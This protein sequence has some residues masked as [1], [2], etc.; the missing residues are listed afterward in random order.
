MLI[1]RFAKEIIIVQIVQKDRW[2]EEVEE[3]V[4]KEFLEYTFKINCSYY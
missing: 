4:E 1:Y 3:V 2:L